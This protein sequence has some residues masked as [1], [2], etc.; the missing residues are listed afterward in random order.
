MQVSLREAAGSVAQN[1]SLYSLGMVMGEVQSNDPAEGL[2]DVNH[3]LHLG[4]V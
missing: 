2:T 1:Q 4:V 3:L